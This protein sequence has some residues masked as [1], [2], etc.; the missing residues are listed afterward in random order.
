LIAEARRS[1]YVVFLRRETPF[2]DVARLLHGEV[3]PAPLFQDYAVSALTGDETALSR[4]DL[5][6]LLGLSS[7]RLVPVA[8]RDRDAVERLA[9][10]G[11]VITEGD[12]SELAELRRREEALER[13]G[14]NLYAALLR[15]RGRWHDVAAG[16][17]AP[18]L[19]EEEARA[20]VEQLLAERG[21]PP[22]AFRPPPAGDAVALP[23][24]E[25]D[26]ALNDV[27]ARRRTTRGFDAAVPL[28]LERLALLLRTVWGPH[29]YARL[30]D[31]VA[32]HKTSPSGGA[33]HPIEVWPLALNVD[34]LEA[35]VYHYG[36]ER[37]ELVPVRLLER[38]AAAELAARFAA[39]QGWV[40]EAQVVFVLSA[41]FERTF[42][43]YRDHEKAYGVVLMD[44][45]HLAQTFALL[46]TELRL[47]T[48]FTAA[49][50]DGAADDVLCLDGVREGVVALC[51][52]GAP[53]PDG[54]DLD[55]V[56]APFVLGRTTI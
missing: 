27:L 8:D 2:V 50:N 41:R 4:P 48:F 44:A 18:A 42:W 51:G 14:W 9:R 53:A 16:V 13:C 19:D 49:V 56:F 43:K 31:L 36:A 45:A 5:D 23:Q 30:H 46:C 47:G 29:G 25:G 52:C 20:L 35:G 32:L 3:V 40:R 17:E 28:A 22:P 1:R 11:L 38:P 7:T 15:A 6:A 33:L 39:G 37:H 26:G 54:S 10:L 12:D 55:P 24:V 34:G 21:L